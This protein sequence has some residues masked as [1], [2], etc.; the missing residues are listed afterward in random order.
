MRLAT[1]VAVRLAVPEECQGMGYGSRAVEQVYRFYNG[2]FV[3]LGDDGSDNEDSEEEPGPEEAKVYRSMAART[4]FV[5]QHRLELLYSAK[6]ICR[7]M[8]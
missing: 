8:A 4:N 5:A 3:D 2:D 1:L 6:E 7:H